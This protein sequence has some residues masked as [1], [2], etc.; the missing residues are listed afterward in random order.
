[1]TKIR[2]LRSLKS[3]ILNSITTSSVGLILNDYTSTIAEES[4][5]KETK[6]ALQWHNGIVIK[7]TFEETQNQ[8]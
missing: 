4:K 5:A 7:Q 6:T 8:P 2:T 1:M 3:I